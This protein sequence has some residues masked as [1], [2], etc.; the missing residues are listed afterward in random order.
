MIFRTEKLRF[1]YLWACTSGLI[2]F[3]VYWCTLAPTLQVADAGEQIAAAHFLGV[4]HPTGTPLYLLLMKGWEWILPFGTIVW[5]M[6]FLNACLSTVT[7]AL[8]SMT[9]LRLSVYFGA[10]KGR[11]LF[12]ALSLSLALS[13]SQ[14]YWYESVA[15]SSY[16]LHYFFVVLYVWIFS[17]VVLRRRHGGLRLLYLVTG[18]A[19]ANHVLSLVLL[20][21]VFWYSFSLALRKEI[22]LREFAF[23]CSFLLPGLSLY[24]YIPLRAASDPLV[25]WGRPDSL[26]RFFHYITRR[27]HTGNLY[28]TGARDL[29][30]IYAFHAK[31][32]FFDLFPL[33]PVLA[34]SSILWLWIGTQND[35]RGQARTIPG[36]SGLLVLTGIFLFIFNLLLLSLHASHLDLFFLKRYMEPGYMGLY[37]SCVVLIVSF[38]SLSPRRVFLG[39]LPLLVLIPLGGFA[40]HF[41]RNDRSQNRLLDT[42]V[43]GLFAHLPEGAALYAEGDNHLFPLLYYHLVE[44]YRPDMILINPSV[45][46]GEKTQLDSL[47]KE[48]RLYTSHYI[49][50]DSVFTC[51]PHGLVFHLT[52]GD[53]PPGELPWKDFCE[54]DLRKAQAPLEKIL[55]TEY[56]HRQAVYHRSRNEHTEALACIRK[57]EKIAEGYDATLMLTGFALAQEDRISE[58]IRYFEAALK[59]NPKNRGSRFYLRRYAGQEAASLPEEG[60]APQTPH[61][62]E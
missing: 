37:F 27:D 35:E 13:F 10:S 31:S 19:L 49:E 59:V 44:G 23:A 30:D 7:V 9:I 14:T 51:K 34:A 53:D 21:L 60:K 33:L 36:A 42:Y 18:L 5:R 11:A 2:T 4:S 52:R 39:F 24:L 3:P 20:V 45:G 61:T 57:M 29:L 43:K 17:G 16:V 1:T 6:N 41:E 38:L 15:A 55:L 58:A 22:T 54:E 26:A 56:Y 32:F 12:L 28:V 62:E 48:G 47:M 46:L 50:T 8:L 40:L 25:N